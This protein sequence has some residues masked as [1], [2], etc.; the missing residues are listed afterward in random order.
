MKQSESARG[1]TALWK[2]LSIAFSVITLALLAFSIYS[3]FKDMMA[4]YHVDLTPI[5]KFMVEETDITAYNDKGERIVLNNQ[6]AY[7]RVV[8]CNR[9]DGS[10]QRE[11]DA[12]SIL[13]DRADL[14]G[15]VGRQWLALYA[16]KYREG[17]PIL[18][19]SLKYVNGNLS[20]DYATGIHEFGSKVPMNLNKKMYLFAD[21]PPAIYVCFN[22]ADHTVSSLLSTKK[23]TP[24]AAGSLFADGSGDGGDSGRLVKGIAIGGGIGIVLGGILGALIMYLSRRKKVTVVEA[25]KKKE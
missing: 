11:K 20:G 25:D 15:D 21:D 23:D 12:F 18:A 16:V 13:G 6:T 5:P 24:G 10:S 4:Y 14:N 3:T 17:E 9:K 7:Y 8:T 2:G 19:N 22:K 1:S